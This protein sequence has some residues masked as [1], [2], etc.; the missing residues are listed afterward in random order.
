MAI[1]KR[2]KPCSFPGCPLLTEK[3]YCILHKHL[4]TDNRPNSNSRGYDRK[5]RLFSVEYLKV[6]KFCVKCGALSCHVHH[7]GGFK[8]EQEKY[9]RK[10]LRALC[11][12]C[13]NIVTKQDRPKAKP[14]PFRKP[15][16][17]S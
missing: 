12:R 7:E 11:H 3:K 1:L 13:H 17:L 16:R 15:Y 2:T 10:R 5:W 4:E 8:N 6:H 14:V 9:D